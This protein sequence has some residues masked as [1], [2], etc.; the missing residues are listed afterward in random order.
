LKDAD[1]KLG[2]QA[3]G[4]KETK[5]HH[6]AQEDQA[7]KNAADKAAKDAAAA[8]KKAADAKKPKAETEASHKVKLQIDDARSQIRVLRAKGKTSVQISKNARQNGVEPV[9]LN[10]ARDLEYL[11]YVSRPNLAA[12]KRAGV[13]VP[14]GWRRAAGGAS[15]RPPGQRPN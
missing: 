9:I 15:P 8:A 1:R 3:G 7:A 4:L 10:A 5:R 12:L 11:G 6:K 13:R 2:V 14:K